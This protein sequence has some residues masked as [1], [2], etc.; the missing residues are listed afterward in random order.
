M[1]EAKT[2]DRDR[3]AA[4]LWLSE[5][6]AA[7]KRLQTWHEKA[8]KIVK[9]YR[10]ERRDAERA[11]G[12]VKKRL[13]L[14][15]SN[16]QTMLPSL[17]AKRPEPICERRFLDRDPVGRVAST[18]WERALRYE[19]EDNGYDETL[20]KAVLD[21]LL[22]GR[23]HAW[24]RY[25]PKFREGVSPDQEAQGDNPYDREDQA[26]RDGVRPG[27]APGDP[28]IDPAQGGGGG[29]TDGMGDG[30]EGDEVEYE[31][32]GVDYVHYK[33]FLFSD[34]PTWEQV[35]WVARRIFMGRREGVERFGEKFKD[36]P[37]RKVRDTSGRTGGEGK[38]ATKATIY[39]IWCIETRS[40]HFVA[41]GHDV[42]LEETPD[43]LHIEGFWPCPRPLS[44]TMTN[45]TL[46]PVPDF[47]EYQDQADDIDSLTN[48]ISMLQ[49]SLRVVGAYDGSAKGLARIMDESMENK[50]VPVD[51]WAAFAEKGGM[52]GAVT[53]LPVKEVAAVLVG[54]MDAL[55]RQKQALYEVTGISD[56]IRGQSDPRETLGAQELKGGFASQ[57]LQKRQKDVAK[58]ARDVVALVGEIVA[59]HFS[60]ATL[61]KISSIM[62]DEGVV[63][64]QP[65][66][67]GMGHN[68]GP[69]MM[70]AGGG[71]APDQGMMIIM[72]ALGLLRDEK[73]RGFRIDLETDSTIALNAESEKKS[74]TEFV[75][76]MGT[77][78]EKAVLGAQAFPPLVPLLG[79][80][81]KFAIR[82][83]R[84]GRDLEQ[85][86]DQFEDDTKKAMAAAQQAGPQ[87]DPKVEAE[88]AKAEADMAAKQADV[89]ANQAKQRAEMQREQM[90][91][92]HEMQLANLQAELEVLKARIELQKMQR[93][94][95]AANAEHQRTM[96]AASMGMIADKAASDAKVAAARQRPNGG[97]G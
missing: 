40:V 4:K 9:R 6:I 33:D 32:T 65:A 60:P 46:I 30:D 45:D 77:F 82:G 74:R 27:Y 92:E 47:A 23:G 18:I 88:K 49:A 83:F 80:M 48:R 90:R 87:P 34:S 67:P 61:I 69:P 97:Q 59:E 11:G 57:R 19:I 44:A 12:R 22:A 17:Y 79:Q 86:F 26:A 39:E 24:V 81:M 2:I 10:D 53:W 38:Q 21:Y 78:L 5:I 91:F 43:P 72:Q 25:A 35:T 70:D 42:Q 3:A 7:E 64:A 71:P 15:W 73:Q 16:V 37:L 14:L 13:N 56:I 76:A 51:N 1:A 8:D 75:T 94:E 84:V 29:Y 58:F 55:E 95:E 85:A 89:A 52:A 66:T 96:E 93:E 28:G 31:R 54:L 50:L 41:E 68:G 36:I 63:A 20:E 62:Q